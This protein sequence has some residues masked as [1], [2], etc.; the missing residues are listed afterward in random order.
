MFSGYEL[1]NDAP[2][3]RQLSPYIDVS[4]PLNTI[5]GNPDL[6]P[7]NRHELYMGFN[8]FDWQSRT[9]FNSFVSANFTNDRVVP[10]S[11][12]SDANVRT[13]TFTNVNGV[14]DFRT[15]LRYGKEI[16]LDTLRT[17]RYELGMGI[18]GNRDVN[19]NNNVEYA[20]KNIRYE[21]RIELR[22]RWKELLE[23]RPQYE[24]SFSQNT[25]NIDRFEN[26]EFTRHELSLRTSTFWPKELEWENDIRFITNPN[27]AQGFQSSSVFWNST[28]AYS[29]LNDQGL[30]T[31]KAY[32]ILD[33]NT[34]ARRTATADYVQDEQSTVLQ[35]YFMLS[36]SYKF[37]TLGKQGEVRE[38]SWFDD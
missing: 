20:S 23:I 30:V 7:S 6:K 21:P 19:F 5:Q 17:L 4:N 8:N 26:R 12:V 13:T 1:N 3:I 28:L 36:F 38:N 18:N 27:V 34:N 14:Y 9:G 22:F 16:V 25:F 10:I 33:Q 32:D 37:N 24:I 29:V 35:Q 15:Q 2:G 11:I 31:L